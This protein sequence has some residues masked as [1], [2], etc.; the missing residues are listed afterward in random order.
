MEELT[1]DGQVRGTWDKENPIPNLNGGYLHVGQTQEEYIENIPEVGF[2]YNGK[3]C[4]HD[5]GIQGARCMECGDYVITKREEKKPLL[6]ES[7]KKKKKY[8]SK[9]E[10]EDA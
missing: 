7:A 2:L 9:S 10:R 8:E 5:G 4:H 6:K 1:P 3:K